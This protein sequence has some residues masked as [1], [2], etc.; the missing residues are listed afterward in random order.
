MADCTKRSVAHEDTKTPNT[1]VSDQA[2]LAVAGVSNSTSIQIP[3]EFEKSQEI[4]AENNEKEKIMEPPMHAVTSNINEKD[5]D[6][7]WTK[8]SKKKGK[9]NL[10]QDKVGHSKP[11]S[12]QHLFK[13]AN[14][15]VFVPSSVTKKA[16]SSQAHSNKDVLNSNVDASPLVLTKT[17]LS[18]I[19]IK[20]QI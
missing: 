8:V 19:H 3:F 5:V 10:V 16:T 9:K 13:Q 7:E 6:E 17:L 14:K 2:P 11:P 18:M 4:N 1:V 15:K 20:G 12:K